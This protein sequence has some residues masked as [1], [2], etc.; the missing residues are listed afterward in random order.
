MM[1]KHM[2]LPRFAYEIERALEK[3]YRDGKCYTTDIGGKSNLS[4]FTE[5]VIKNIE[6]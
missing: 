2:G 5:E 1:L 3:T 4:Q 6:Q